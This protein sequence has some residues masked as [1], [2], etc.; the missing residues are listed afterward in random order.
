MIGLS[1]IIKSINNR[2]IEIDIEKLNGI[3]FTP[4][5][6]CNPL[7][8]KLLCWALQNWVGN[9]IEIGVNMGATAVN[10]CR[11]NPSKKIYGVDLVDGLTMHTS[12]GPEQPSR[13]TVGILCREQPNFK[14]ILANSWHIEIPRNIGVVFIDADHSYAGVKNDTE[15]ILKQVNA[16][17]VIFWHDYSN[18]LHPDY[19]RV[20]EYIDKEVAPI[21]PLYEF[22]NTWLIAGI[23]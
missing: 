9:Y 19:L 17:T 8:I 20:N 7:E 15:N 10:V 12:Q 1:P 13:D 5:V 22:E 18:N 3:S 11:N 14:L 2:V 4:G 23:T 6:Y 16:G 21:M